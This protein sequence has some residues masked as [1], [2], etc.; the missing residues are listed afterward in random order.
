MLEPNKKVDK[1][2]R[3]KLHTLYS[4]LDKNTFNE[5]PEVIK[6]SELS[7]LLKLETVLDFNTV[8][9]PLSYLKHLRWGT[10]SLEST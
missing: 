3:E 8:A 5:A 10:I 1:K 4:S 7:I 9:F 6:N 2:L